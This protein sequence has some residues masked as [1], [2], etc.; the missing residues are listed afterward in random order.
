M[1]EMSIIWLMKYLL[2]CRLSCGTL[3]T[4]TA[5]RATRPGTFYGRN[6]GRAKKRRTIS[7]SRLG[8]DGPSICFPSWSFH[9]PMKAR[10]ALRALDSPLASLW[11]LHWFPAVLQE[12]TF[13]FYF[14]CRWYWA[15]N[16]FQYRLADQITLLD[17]ISVICVLDEPQHNT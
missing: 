9:E 10:R 11:Y 13:C 15:I 6:A 7:P 5:C 1:L 4:Q 3:G 2:G 12:N 14:H 8:I 17:F 16:S